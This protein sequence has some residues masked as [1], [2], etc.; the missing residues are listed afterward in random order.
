MRPRYSLLPVGS[1]HAHEEV[2][3]EDVRSLAE[4]L[5]AEG[6]L[7]EPIWVASEYDVILNG[8]HRY[9]ALERLGTR[10]VPA[11]LLDYF[12]DDVRLSRWDPGP[13]IT[14][15]E[16]VDRARSGRLFPPKTTRHSL[17][18]KLPARPTTLSDLYED[19][20][21]SR[22]RRPSREDAWSSDGT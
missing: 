1:L 4:E 21:H 15:Q 3:V 8:H 18:F 6:I 13:P 12:T 16:V 2:E 5:R 11:W 14:K 7:T 9:A 19:G 17:A 20:H 22:G 10:Y